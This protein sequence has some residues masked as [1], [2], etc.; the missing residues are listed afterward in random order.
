VV[1][2]CLLSEGKV[3][4]FGACEH[5]AADRSGFCCVKHIFGVKV[6]VGARKV[7]CVGWVV[8]RG[9]GVVWRWVKERDFEKMDVCA[10]RGFCS[11]T[12]K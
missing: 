4:R 7:D 3:E 5:V 11:P 8:G 6:G 1:V 9:R 2:L 12:R 10:F